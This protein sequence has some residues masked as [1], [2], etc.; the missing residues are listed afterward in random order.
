MN[1]LL[2]THV[3]LWWDQHAA[4]AASAR[5]AIEDP[6]NSVFISAAS[7]WEIAIKRRLGKLAFEGSASAAI[8]ANGF[9]E[10]PIL[11]RDAEEAGDLPWQHNDPFDRLLVAQAIRQGMSMVTADRAIRDFGA[12]PVL[13]AG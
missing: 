4:L 9:L 1:L 8:G 11:P 13:W 6:R 7:I 2:D 5:A 12:V 10:L 3:F